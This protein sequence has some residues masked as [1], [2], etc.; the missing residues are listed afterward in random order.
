MDQPAGRGPLG[1]RCD[2]A[3]HVGGGRAGA[4]RPLPW[5][6]RFFGVHLC[7]DRDAGGDYR[8]FAVAAVRCARARPRLL[9]SYPR[10]HNRDTVLRHADR[11]VAAGKF[12]YKFGGS[13]NGPRRSA[14]AHLPA[15]HSAADLAGNRL[16]LGPGLHAVARRP[17]DRELY[18]RSGRDHA[19]DPNLFR[20]PAG[21]EAQHQ[22]HLHFDDRDGRCRGGRGVADRQARCAGQSDDR[23]TTSYCD[24]AA[25]GS[26]SAAGEIACGGST[27]RVSCSI[28]ERTASR[29]R[30]PRAASSSG[31]AAPDRRIKL[32]ASGSMSGSSQRPRTTNGSSKAAEAPA[33]LA[34]PFRSRSRAGIEAEPS[35]ARRTVGPSSLTSSMPAVP[36]T[37]FTAIASR[38]KGV[39]PPRNSPAPDSG[40][41]SRRRNNCST[42]TPVTAPLAAVRLPE[43]LMVRVSASTSL[44]PASSARATLPRPS[45]RRTPNT[46]LMQLSRSTSVNCSCAFRSAPRSDLAS[47]R[48]P[49][50]TP[51]KACDS[52]IVST[53]RPPRRLAASAVRPSSEP[54]STMRAADSRRSNSFP[55]SPSTRI[56]TWLQSRSLAPSRRAVATYGVR[57]IPSAASV[58]CNC[59]RPSV[60][61]V[62]TPSAALPSS[63]TCTLDKATVEPIA[64][65][66]ALSA[67]RPKPPPGNGSCPI[68]CSALR[69]EALSAANVPSIFNVGRRPICPSKASLRGAPL[70]RSLIP[71]RS[72]V[73]AATKS[74][75]LTLA[76]TFSP[77]HTN[78]PVAPKLFE[79]DGQAS[80]SSTALRI[81]A[82]SCASLRIITVPP[83][84]RISENETGT[85]DPLAG[86][87]VPASRASRPSQL[88]R[89]A[90]ST[91][92]RI[93]G[94]TR[95]TSA[96]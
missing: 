84:S 85:C 67:K 14:A 57:S 90:W 25:G 96:T 32:C 11:A 82:R 83:T 35:S 63:S 62:S 75:R 72:P 21:G 3:R 80:D 73:S 38:S 28:A 76:S 88:E 47:P 1:E 49:L 30:P 58:P 77:R 50:S 15:D 29:A 92:I 41:R 74:V 61:N 71:E 20:R 69:S 56:G 48:A 7:A 22:R 18:D 4:A 78:C 45:S 2:C 31:A 66:C 94:R 33:R 59:R 19:A 55:V 79:I 27:P 68:H 10:A 13:R 60:V 81:S 86:F 65:A 51:P 36:S 8:A 44:P 6:H 52:P 9:D 26:A 91:L 34:R 39:R 70:M 89:P 24:A 64:L 42:L 93:S 54:A 53:K 43:P 87:L 37:T 12:R 17:R 46:A 5:P 16:R 40:R 95:V 23:L